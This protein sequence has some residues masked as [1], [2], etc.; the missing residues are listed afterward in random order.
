MATTPPPRSSPIH[1]PPTPLHGAKYDDWEP[2]GPRRSARVSS[3]RQASGRNLSGNSFSPPL[4]IHASPKKRDRKGVH[5]LL[6]ADSEE[7]IR[8]NT[9]SDDGEDSMPNEKPGLRTTATIPAS[10]M[11]PT[12]AKTPRKRPEK[13]AHA[14]RATARVLFPAR[15]ETADE[16]MPSP[17]KTRKYQPF[18]LDSSMSGTSTNGGDNGIEIFTDSKERVPEVDASEDNPF[19]VSPNQSAQESNGRGKRRRAVE[20]NQE[21]EEVVRRDDGM[22]YTLYV[23][24]L[25]TL[26]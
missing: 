21:I 26:S 14:L 9:V 7:V 24:C 11:L 5:I 19:L 2:Y 12:P 4:S 10:T 13:S 16:A 20:R 15:P 17:R 8:D 1:T 3:Q 25:A 18:S 6:Q 22:F 23:W